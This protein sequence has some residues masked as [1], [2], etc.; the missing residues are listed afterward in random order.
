MRSRNDPHTINKNV[1]N[2]YTT[3][4]MS[5]IYACETYIQ[6]DIRGFHNMILEG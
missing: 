2:L 6:H 1:H 4:H 5:E 3:T